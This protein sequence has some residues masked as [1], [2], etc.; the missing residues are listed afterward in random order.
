[1]SRARLLLTDP[2]PGPAPVPRAAYQSVPGPGPVHHLCNLSRVSCKCN[3]P[4]PLLCLSKVSSISRHRQRSCTVRSNQIDAW[5]AST[6]AQ[7]AQSSALKPASKAHPPCA[8]VR[9]RIVWVCGISHSLPSLRRGVNG[10]HGA[11]PAANA[12]HWDPICSARW[13]S[14]ASFGHCFCAT[15]S[16]GSTGKQLSGP[17]DCQYSRMRGG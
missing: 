6:R 9:R 8:T 16:P 7:N 3:T 13:A 14:D 15:W 4:L 5:F 10:A 17:C 2:V 11:W 12:A 1:M